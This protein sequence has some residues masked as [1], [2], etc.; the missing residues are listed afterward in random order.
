MS[1]PAPHDEEHV[2]VDDAIIGRV[3]WRSLAVVTIVALVVSGIWFATRPRAAVTT[4]SSEPVAAPVQATPAAPPEAVPSIPFTDITRSAG[5]DFDR[6]SGADGR[7]LLPETLGGGAGFVDVN[8][9]GHPDLVLVDGDAWPDAPDGARRGRGTVIYLNDGRGNFTLAVDT[10]LEAPRQGMGFAAADLDG[11]GLPELAITTTEGVILFRNETVPGNSKVRFRDITEESGIR[12]QGWSTTAMFLDAD[13]DGH[14]DLLVAHYVV[15]SPE[16]DF[17]VD[18]RLD[19]VN[20][21]YGPPLGFEGT[22][23]SL[24]RNDGAGRFT[25]VSAEAGLHVVNPSTGVAVGKTLGLLAEDFNNDGRLDLFVANDRTA[26]FLFE[27]LGGGRFREIGTAAGVAFDRAGASTGAMGVDAARLRTADEIGIAVGNF[28][29]EPHS[30]YMTRGGRLNFSDDALVEGVGAPTR[31]SLSFG[32]LFLDLDLDGRPDLVTANGHIEDQIESIQASQAYA[33]RAQAFW[34]AGAKA[35]RLFVEIP[36]EKIGDLARPVV[37]RAL[38]AAD[39]D[40]DGDIDLLITQPQGAVLLLRNDQAL[41]NAFTRVRLRGSP[42]NRDAIG[43]RV[44]CISDAGTQVQWVQPSRSYLTANELPLTFGLG[45]SA[46]ATIRV[47]WPNGDMQEVPAVMR[48][49]TEVTQVPS[50]R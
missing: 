30:L 10:G 32:T 1:A 31:L 34:N 27:N 15:W 45:K 24:W 43:A 14:L 7:K 50:V 33:Q 35:P 25:E 37:G 12:D 8:G 39:I 44:E 18:Y 21:A 9:N 20:R 29:N 22:Q 17:K 16:I 38:A 3:F 4:G 48:G 28:A 19:G 13:G 47:R 5:I 41:G 11:D 26:N 2:P 49:L 6:I 40:G 42:P 36:P 46:S 23:L